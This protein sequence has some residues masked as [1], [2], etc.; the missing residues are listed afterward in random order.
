MSSQIASSELVSDGLITP[1]VISINEKEIDEEIRG[2]EKPGGLFPTDFTIRAMAIHFKTD[3]VL[4]WSEEL[5]GLKK[6]TPKEREKEKAFA[7]AHLYPL[8][9][10]M[11]FEKE[12][13]AIRRT[14]RGSPGLLFQSFDDFYENWYLKEPE[15]DVCVLIHN[16]SSKYA[17]YTATIRAETSTD[18]A[19]NTADAD[20]AGPSTADGGRRM[21]VEN[22]SPDRAGPSN[23]DVEED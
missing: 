3:I 6:C 23:A 13:D 21:D 4:M 19:L 5:F 14:P 22:I 20:R 7:T 16:A 18:K 11:V 1:E 17:H 8:T 10:V 9:Q 2:I 12:A 15:R